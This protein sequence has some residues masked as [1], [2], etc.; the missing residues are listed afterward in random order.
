MVALTTQPPSRST[1][2]DTSVPPPAKLTRS[3]TLARI[4]KDGIGQDMPAAARSG[5]GRV[6]A[7]ERRSAPGLPV[8]QGVLNQLDEDVP[9]RDV[10]LLDVLHGVA[11]RGDRHIRQAPRVPPV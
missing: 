9:D 2:G 11:G 5:P 3:G 10:Q 4:R 6:A 1:K 8:R 7:V